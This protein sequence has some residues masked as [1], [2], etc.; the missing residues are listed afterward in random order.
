MVILGTAVLIVAWAASFYRS[1]TFGD[2]GWQLVAA[3]GQTLT[4]EVTTSAC[5]WIHRPSVFESPHSVEIHVRWTQQPLPCSG[6]A[7]ASEV[8]VTLDRP[9]GERTLVGCQGP[10]YGFEPSCRES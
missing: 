1:N 10:T 3:R 2:D 9:L 5:A 6:Q 7:V 4:L 8:T